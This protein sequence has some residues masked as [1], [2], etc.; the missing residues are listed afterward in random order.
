MH[1][2]EYKIIYC[3]TY[4]IVS[5][6]SDTTG[7]RG[8]VVSSEC[9]LYHLRLRDSVRRLFDGGEA[10]AVFRT[11]TARAASHGTCANND[12]DFRPLPRRYEA[13]R[14]RAHCITQFVPDDNRVLGSYIPF[15]M[16]VFEPVSGF[17]SGTFNTTA[18]AARRSSILPKFGKS[19]LQHAVSNHIENRN[20]VQY[21]LWGA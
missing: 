16:V 3:F 12:S 5:T 17:F 9:D 10:A 13:H 1:T 4:A 14:K 7:V 8:A 2:A 18:D 21:V 19:A 6:T 15:G 20:Y 11:T